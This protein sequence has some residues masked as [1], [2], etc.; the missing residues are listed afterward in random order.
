MSGRGTSGGVSFQAEV[1]A[2]I[3]GLLLAERPL[4]RLSTG[5]PGIPQKIFFEAPFAVDDVIIETDCG[6]VYIQAKRTISVS[7]KPNEELASV[8]D[9]FVKQFRLGCD[10]EG[11]RRELS[12][13]RDR[14][15]LAVSDETAAP[16]SKNLKEAL[17]RNR[18]GAATALP[19]KISSVLQTFSDLIK[20]SWLTA[21]GLP[22]TPV[23]LQSILSLC[24]VIVIG[25][26][27]RQLVTEILK[28]VVSALG[29]E[30]TLIDLLL[31]W[32]TDASKSGTGGDAI[33]IRLALN[34]K[35]RLLSPPSFRKDINCLNA[36]N[37][38]V[39]Q[40]LKRFTEITAPEGNITIVRPIADL[41]VEA[42]KE[43]S[44]VI[45][46]E[47]G[48][49][50][51]AIIYKV[52]QELG[53]ERIVVTLTVDAHCTSLD[54]LRKEIGLEHSLIEVFKQMSVNG[55]AHLILD[56]L[57]AIRGGIAES[58]YKRLIE[59]VLEIPG[60]H[61][62]ASVRT[63]DL[64]LGRDWQR[65]FKGKPPYP[66]HADEKFA[67][68]RH[69]HIGLLN[70]DEKAAFV[71]KSLSIGRTINVGGPKME[72]LAR[73]PFNLALL[74]D[75]LTGG[76][77]TDSLASVTTR[78]ELLKRYWD[79]RIEEFGTPAI[80]GLKNVVTLMLT[81][82]SID[83]PVSEIPIS[84]ASMVDTLQ[85]A[86]VLITEISHRVG[87]RHH[88]LFDYA[89]ARLIF[90]PEQN[91]AQ[92]YLARS[93]G[94]GFLISPALGY[95]L[96]SLKQS[97]SPDKYW[98]FMVEL[99]SDKN[100][101]PLVR[102][103]TA[104]VAVESVQ[105]G[106]DLQFLANIFKENDPV[107]NQ[108][109][110]HLAGS[111]ITKL[112]SKQ[113]VVSEP[114]AH[115]LP[116]MNLSKPE[117][118]GNVRALIGALLDSENNPE[119]MSS[120]GTA[121]RNLFDIMSENE[122]LISWLSPHVTPFM[123]R[124]YGTD[125]ISSGNRLRKIFEP[126]RF[127]HSGHIEVPWLTEKVLDIAE[128]DGEFTVELFYLVFRGGKFI[129]EQVTSISRSWIFS[130]TSNAAQDYHLAEHYLSGAFP[131]ILQ[132][133]PKIGARALA[134]TLLGEREKNHY[135]LE[136]RQVSTLILED[137]KRT[138]EDDLSHSWA[139]NIDVETHD[140][141]SKIYQAFMEWVLTVNDVIFLKELPDLLLNQ[142]C[143]AIVWRVLFEIAAKKPETLGKVMWRSAATE[144][145][146]NSL[147]TTQSAIN[148]IAATYPYLTIL[149]KHEIEKEW[150]E[151]DFL[152]Y[153]EPEKARIKI[154]GTLFQCIGEKELATEAA[155]TFLKGVKNEDENFENRKPFE[156]YNIRGGEAYWMEEEEISNED[157]AP[158]IALNNLVKKEIYAVEKNPE[159]IS[160]LWSTLST[161][162]KAITEAG[163]E[164][165]PLVDR[166][167]SDTLA[168]G[169]GLGLSK[170]LI[171]EDLRSIALARLLSLTHHSYPKV[172]DNT[173]GNISYF[174]SWEPP[175][176]RIKAAQALASLVV[177]PELWT[178]IRGRF[179]D[180]LLYDLHPVV[181]L[182]LVCVLPRL[183][184]IDINA[185]WS[186][187]ESVV[188][189]EKNRSIIQHFGNALL[190]LRNQHSERLEP[191]ILEILKLSSSEQ[192]GNDV[193]VGHI[194][195][196]AIS[197]GYISSNTVLQEWLTDY[198]KNESRLRSVL[199]DIRDGIVFGIDD[200]DQFKDVIR[201]RV[202]KFMWS[203]IEAV[204]TAVRSWPT[205]GRSPT[206]EEKAALNLFDAV[207]DQI[208]FAVGFDKL[209]Q[210]LVTKEAQKIF[211]LE[212]API[213]SKLTT[214]GTPRTVHHLL[215]VL[216][217]LIDADPE[218]CFDLFS[219]AM[220]RTTGIARYEYESMGATLF[221]EL[222]GLYLADHRSIFVDEIRRAKLTDC[223]ALFVEAGWPEARQLFQD[224]SDL[225]R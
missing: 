14:L 148:A 88:I 210:D 52:S 72:S 18:T 66:Q 101:D 22:I 215:Q 98:R 136:V 123:A 177:I 134:M 58:T 164:I 29:D 207:A 214:L 33:T 82:R 5:L 204:E 32:V 16:I 11:Q 1:G 90:I 115:L 20:T 186:L 104:R 60:W 42:A 220:L 137:K 124:T 176:P 198:P 76:I 49:G 41:I 211:L 170:N 70:E 167:A 222:V 31:T 68:V 140:N 108:V 143:I 162:E 146:L 158:I 172:A 63:F 13:F 142:S 8:A 47:P 213:I 166:E 112:E 34:E 46:G 28:E 37:T 93:G 67:V 128:H 225:L 192:K 71:S 55:P 69:V 173:E 84:A 86:G 185:M 150:L 7:N 141:H 205:D 38:R 116:K 117:L 105:K 153:L 206:E 75:L 151:R 74:G 119:S 27:Q 100:I 208:N 78:S 97:Y 24:S 171:P 92:N 189:K 180:M 174:L 125:P 149:D 175:S 218:L 6:K 56:A 165:N 182:Q 139:W 130:A 224:L 183:R 12:P 9:Q 83:V 156:V 203:L 102:V 219:E 131:E 161:L 4:S 111:L 212:Y 152:K 195:F 3:A 77:K 188:K 15:I 157:V 110:G 202:R 17:D 2:Y 61:V 200:S 163:E 169:L 40:R 21:T 54:I 184:H 89:V 43:G 199:F 23:E 91:V 155:R 87:F 62:I 96:E 113:R 223:L 65:L 209:T 168:E 187:V 193:I 79:E 44:L 109:F 127:A 106:E 132:R 133:F 178:Q 80:I 53:K 114:W 25:D 196:F 160:D 35:I 19:I 99:I 81:S 135:S 120:L 217:K 30:A 201:T 145:A 64:R 179:E 122:N 50:K 190:V 94:M 154:L 57:D 221:V 197:K 26:S 118:L 181:R 126:D 73:N 129:R 95:W 39:V 121:T 51:S 45:T 107:K 191:F 147:D 216:H 194:V 36:Y 138:F 159:Q 144:I 48:A 59:E 85:H 103:E 10:E